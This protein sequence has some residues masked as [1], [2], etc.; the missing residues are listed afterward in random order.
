M[1][2]DICYEFLIYPGFDGVMM[3]KGDT[4]S[5]RPRRGPR[6]HPSRRR[7]ILENFENFLKKIA[8][9]TLLSL[10]FFKT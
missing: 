10:T 7:R 8:K 2:N 4:F 5:H 3:G 9:I 6:A 1:Q